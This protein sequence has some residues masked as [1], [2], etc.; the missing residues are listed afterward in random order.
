MWRKTRLS[1]KLNAAGMKK[2]NGAIDKAFKETV[3]A[4]GDECKSAIESPIWEWTDKITHREN[5]EIVGSPRNSVDMGDL[6]NSQQEPEFDGDK[7]TIE[8]TS[9][10]A[11]TVHEGYVD[12][13]IYPA[14]PWT[15]EAARNTDFEGIMG[16]VLKRELS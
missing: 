7:A 13:S 14:R 4:Y 8:W 12:Q 1:F 5:G 3:E 6:I 11:G 2:L 9:D 10:H 16:E 15:E